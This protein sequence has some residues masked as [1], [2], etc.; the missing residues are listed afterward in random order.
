MGFQGQKRLVSFLILLGV[1]MFLSF[2]SS[3]YCAISSF[4]FVKLFPIAVSGTFLL[5]IVIGLVGAIKER[6]KSLR[7]FAI[8]QSFI[9]AFYILSL[10]VFLIHQV[11]TANEKFTENHS[12]IYEAKPLNKANLRR[13]I[14]DLND[15]DDHHGNDHHGNDHRG[16]DH[17]GN[18]H[19]GNDHH[20]ND[21]R[22]NDHHGN[23]HHGNDHRDGGRKWGH[24]RGDHDD[25]QTT[26]REENVPKNSQIFAA[27]NLETLL[28]ETPEKKSLDDHETLPQGNESPKKENPESTKKHAFPSMFLSL[29]ASLT[30]MIIQLYTIFLAWDGH[31][32][33]IAR[34]VLVEAEKLVETELVCPVEQQVPSGP[35]QPLQ[36]I[37]VPTNAP[38]LIPQDPNSVLRTVNV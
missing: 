37:Y 29:F 36:V 3:I 2:G 7:A 31:K 30:F 13:T 26:G 11:K 6:P 17:R 1:V 33:I 8:M 18:D 27:E 20:G 24:H 5:V 35:P 23:D 25:S 4:Q 15:K 28:N 12:V 34:A 32:E 38:F 21:H 14:N 22:G 10:S 9:L 19:L 16:N